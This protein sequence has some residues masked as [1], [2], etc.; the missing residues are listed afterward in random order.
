M[1]EFSDDKKA[2]RVVVDYKDIAEHRGERL[3]LRIEP[4]KGVAAVNP[5]LHSDSVEYTLVR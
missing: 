4:V 2:V 5:R 3:P 1:S